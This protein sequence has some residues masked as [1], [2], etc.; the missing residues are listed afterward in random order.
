MSRSI[1]IVDDDPALLEALTSLISLRLDNIHLHTA[2]LP[3][4]AL[5]LVAAH[6]YDV[7]LSDIKLPGMNGLELLRH[8][9]SMR[10]TTPVV[11]MTGHGDATLRRE[12]LKAGAVAFLEKPF[13][14]NFVISQ[15]QDALEKV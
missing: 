13:D 11:M 12:A 3:E 8:I 1:L 15:L 9:R 5:R 4:D 7:V 10:P 14:R 6:D 2:A